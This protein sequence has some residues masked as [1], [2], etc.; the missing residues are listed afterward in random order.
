M[1]L[2]PKQQAVAAGFTIFPKLEG[3]FDAL[4]KDKASTFK[5][6]QFP[7]GTIFRSKRHVKYKYEYFRV[8]DTGFERVSESAWLEF[9]VSAIPPAA[10]VVADVQQ[11]ADAHK[12][13]VT[14]AKPKAEPKPKKE[15]KPAEAKQAVAESQAPVPAVPGFL[16]TV[17]AGATLTAGIKARVKAMVERSNIRVGVI[18]L[19]KAAALAVVTRNGVVVGTASLRTRDAEYI[20]RTNNQSQVAPV[21][22]NDALEL[23]WIRTD[24]AGTPDTEAVER[25]A[26]SALREWASVSEKTVFA[27]YNTSDNVGTALM[28]RVQMRKHT[29]THQGVRKTAQLY[30]S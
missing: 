18:D 10:A 30:L 5:I 12:A 3:F 7:A 1:N 6:S 14:A 28:D 9:L 4:D 25:L 13:A 17:V 24:I 20:N 15:K 29:R 27:V 22:P 21:L 8:T 23:C 26:V 16:V 2:T 19:D 11:G